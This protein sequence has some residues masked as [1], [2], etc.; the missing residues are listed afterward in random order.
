MTVQTRYHG[1]LDALDD[2]ARRQLVERGGTVDDAIRETVAEMA[3]RIREDGDAAALAYTERFD[4]VALEALSVPREAW[5]D[6]RD[7]APAGF[8]DAFT[9]AAHQI[10]AYHEALT[11]RRSAR[12]L[13]RGIQAHERLEPVPRAGVYVPGGTA[14]YPS[15]VAM[16]VVP[17]QVAG[18]DDVTVASPPGPDGHP[19]PLVLA[20]CDLLDVDRVVPL[21]GAQAVL[22]L[23]LGTDSVPAHPVV[24]GPGNAY[25][26]AAKE[27]VAGR[28]RIDAPAGPSEIIVLVGPRAH[29][30]AVARELAAQAEHAP[31]TLA[32]AI[33]LDP[34]TADDVQAALD[35][36]VPELDR[37][38]VVREAL[39][40]RGGVLTVDTVD[41]ARAFL[42]EL[43]PE[44]CLLMHEA[45]DELAETLTGPACIVHGPQ[46]S[47][48]LTDYAAGPSHVLPTGGHARAYAGVGLET[49]TKR[50]HVVEVAD[51]DPDLHHA[52]AT[53]A[54]LE[55]L[56]AHASALEEEAA[57]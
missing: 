10:R 53:L 56:T 47:I 33:C 25:V 52:A 43:A 31:D 34:G 40:T 24:V 44:H 19:H 2:D 39:K 4:D 32:I 54:R 1:P 50:V 26:Q 55:G 22:S 3:R 15:T 23:A 51:P 42:D 57:P 38:G 11:V 49:F 17:A 35:H 8:E 29:P 20:A 6:A 27:H 30:R 5:I 28:V 13:E 7:D 21:G 41:E 37:S 12:F 14:A 16:T 46:A 36:V 18:V 48:P 45:S 9:T